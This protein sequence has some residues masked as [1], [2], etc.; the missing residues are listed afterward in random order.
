MNEIVVR[1]K[2]DSSDIVKLAEELKKL[3]KQ[4]AEN[5]KQF[6]KTNDEFKKQTKESKDSIKELFSEVT[7]INGQLMSLGKTIVAAFAIESIIEF[8]KAS[9]EAFME[10]ELNAKKLASAVKNIA[11]EST[12]SFDKLITQS[13]RLQDKSIFS[14]DAI[15]AAQ[16]Q[17]VQF[18]LTSDAVEQLVPRLID[19]ASAT[20]EDLA[21]ATDLAIQGLNGMPRGLKRLGAEFKDTGTTMGNF[22]ELMLTTQKYIGQSEI[23][24]NTSAGQLAN[25]KNKWDDIKESIGG[26]TLKFLDFA[27]FS[28]GKYANLGTKISDQF[29]EL[30]GAETSA[31]LAAR[32]AA[33]NA[34]IQ[35]EAAEEAAKKALGTKKEEIKNI[36]YYTRAIQTQDDIIKGQDSTIS[37]INAALK[38]KAELEETLT[39][40]LGKQTEA[41]KEAAKQK[42]E[43]DKKAIQLSQ[44]WADAIVE[45]NDKAD[46]TNKQYF[47]NTSKERA[48]EAKQKQADI[49][50]ENERFR[51][52][53]KAQ[54]ILI[55]SQA[56]RKILFA[57]LFGTETDV[58]NAEYEKQKEDLIKK[59]DDQKQVVADAGEDVTILEETKNLALQD[60]EKKHQDEMSD[61]QKNGEEKRKKTK[62]EMATATIEFTIGLGKT[63]ID[64]MKLQGK[65]A[66]AAQKG[67]A[68]ADIAISTAKAIAYLTASSAQVALEIAKVSGPAAIFTGPAAYAAYYGTQIVT[69]L[70]NMLSAKQILGYEKGTA[71]LQR[72]GNPAG[73]DTIPI[74]ANE[75]EAIIP[76]DKNRQSPGLAAAWIKGNLDDFINVKYVIPALKKNKQGKDDAFA[77]RLGKAIS[78]NGTF[79]DMNLLESDKENRRILRSID[80]TLKSG[81][82]GLSRRKF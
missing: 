65:E 16:T 66:E 19:L 30:F 55:S 57:K 6:K 21:S 32:E 81:S 33:S 53:M 73:V 23:V 41:E 54:E 13:E 42:E 20:G 24:L 14:D 5:A 60:L 79:N 25:Y 10:A 52:A 1:I 31:Q 51:S 77:D 40:L 37:Q 8:G 76:T 3:G 26:T 68:L 18:G 34:I 45:A 46:E 2:G 7:D 62:L 47:A 28:F 59:Y 15:Q 11:G 36:Y 75:G 44:D 38:K 58:A 70:A 56:D 72:N 67:F 69:I 35:A 9:V 39:H 29:K 22:N 61:I 43:D 4:D 63:L 82:Y 64:A 50:L 27:A 12:A 71:S 17:L 48:E 74:M 78:L 49:D 80:K